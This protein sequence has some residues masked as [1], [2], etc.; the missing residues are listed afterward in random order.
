MMIVFSAL[1]FAMLRDGGSAESDASIAPVAVGC[2]PWAVGE[3][4]RKG[5]GFPDECPADNPWLRASYD[6]GRKIA[7]LEEEL[8]VIDDIIA[9]SARPDQTGPRGG[10]DSLLVRRSRLQEELRD[11][12]QARRSRAQG[13][14]P[15]RNRDDGRSVIQP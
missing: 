15:F 8:H 7:S 5:R 13:S 12:E 6:Q 4:G 11:A 9:A 1:G 10:V 3:H 2:S 14:T